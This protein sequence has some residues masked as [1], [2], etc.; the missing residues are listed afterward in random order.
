MHLEIVE[1]MVTSILC[2]GVQLLA[3]GKI[4]EPLK[5]A[6]VLGVPAI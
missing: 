3:G 1:P 5:V 4:R 6:E 2:N